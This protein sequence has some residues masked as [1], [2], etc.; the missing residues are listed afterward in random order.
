VHILHLDTVGGLPAVVNAVLGKIFV[1]NGFLPAWAVEGLAVLHEGDGDGSPGR[2]GNALFD[3]YAR[4]L[5]TEG[6]GLPSLDVTSNPM[7]GWPRGS[8]P[9]L[10]GGRF[11]G[12]LQERYGA[13][14]VAGF[15]ADQGTA[16]WPWAPGWFGD[17]WFGGKDFPELWADFRADLEARYAAQLAR[18]RERPVTRPAWLTRRGA[19]VENPRWSPD[20]AWVAFFDRSLDR[21]SG[22]WRV[23]PAG[24][25]LGRA[26]V[27]YQNGTFALRSARIAIV[28]AADVWREYRLYGDLRAIDLW[29]GDER[30][31]TDGERATDPDVVPGGD[32]VVYVAH[33]GDGRLALRRRPIR[34]TG[35]ALV[36]GEPET[37][38]DRPGALEFLPRVSPDGRRIA[39]ELHE[40]G[41]RDIALWEDGAVVRVTDDQAMDLSPAWTPDGRWLLWASD[42]GGIY[43]L[44]AWSAETKAVRQVTN[45]E[46]GALQPTVSPDGRTIAFVSYSRAGYDLA[47]IPFDPETWLEPFPAPA[48]ASA[49][50]EGMQPIGERSPS[51]PSPDVAPAIPSRPYSPLQTL[52]PHFWLPLVGGDGAGTTLG[53]FTSGQDVVGIHSWA[54]QGWWG[55]ESNQPGYALSYLGGWSWPRLDLSSSRYVIVSPG[56]PERLQSEWTVADA[57]ATF[58]FTSLERALALRVGWSGT[59][60]D[61]L[62]P[63]DPAGYPPDL[64]FEDGFLSS[65][66][67]SVAYSDARRFAS[68]I[69]LEEGKSLALSLS[70]AGPATGSDFEI[71]RARAAWAGYARVPGTAHTVLALRLAGGI[72]RGTFGGRAPFSL[73]GI[74]P[75]DPLSLLLLVPSAPGNTLRGYPSGA[76][77]GNAYGLLNLELR[78]PL[79]APELGR[80]TW[81]VFLRR[82]SG[83]VFVDAGEAFEVGD[84]PFHGQPFTWDQVRFGAGAELRLEAFLGYYLLTEVRVGIAQGLGPLLGSWENGWPA[85]P[86]AITQV[87]VTL[88]SG[89]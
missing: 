43:D 86:D 29:T 12:F 79:G 51:P 33:V 1:P 19:Q 54:L 14:A 40:G 71:A 44:Y 62:D 7:L 73:G 47:T 55:I 87:Y 77:D 22:L 26:A 4:A 82:V 74:P 65:V 59:F 35:A 85:D 83:A 34:G 66:S 69:S 9:Y 5:V 53:A 21:R 78:F 68:S 36:L 37:L 52:G 61:S 88:G 57:G 30:R 17:E 56:D 41:R 15:V 58:T 20:G 89:F 31:L 48:A 75:F 38:L 42:R 8:A 67:L 46:T 24:E 10:L 27:V 6:D 49:E 28:A 32:A 60:F 18:V 3:M 70:A 72:A 11:L 80:S 63:Y 16:I 23:T 84:E 25:D 39:F 50:K 76:F 45:V 2:N 81:P 64:V 13:E